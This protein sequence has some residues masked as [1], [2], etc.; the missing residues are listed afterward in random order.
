MCRTLCSGSGV[1]DRMELFFTPRE[2]NAP[3]VAAG[4]VR[5]RNI[6]HK[7]TPSGVQVC[8]ARHRATCLF[9][10]TMAASEEV[11]VGAAVTSV[12]SAPER[13]KMRPQK[14]DLQ[15][16]HANDFGRSTNRNIAIKQNTY[17]K[18]PKYTMYTKAR[19]VKT[20][21]CHKYIHA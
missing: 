8:A 16:V 17:N 19:N 10:A 1:H 2:L 13:T 21:K 12:V 11:S 15:M 14:F 3:L 5:Y 18:G 20:V 7:S 4:F 9:P 6:S